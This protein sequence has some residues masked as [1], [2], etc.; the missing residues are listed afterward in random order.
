MR[1]EELDEILGEYAPFLRSLNDNEDNEL[2]L[3]IAP[4]R[5]DKRQEVS[6]SGEPNDA[7]RSLLNGS[8]PLLPNK[9]SVYEI[10]FDNYIIYQV[11]SESFC[12]GSPNEKYTGRY[13]RV[14][15]KSALLNRLGEFSDA[16]T[17]ADGSYYPGKWTHYEVVTQNHVTDVISVGKPIVNIL[18]GT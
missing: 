14:Y 7:L 13:L 8:R 17:L 11:G 2:T 4:T 5:V 15:E 10:V 16:Q 6:E 12:S 18:L 9:Q 1:F 3:Q